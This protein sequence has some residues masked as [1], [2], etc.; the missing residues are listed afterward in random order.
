MTASRSVEG[1]SIFY[2]EEM[3]KSQTTNSNIKGTPSPPY[4]KDI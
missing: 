4:E 1:F 2:K 3:N